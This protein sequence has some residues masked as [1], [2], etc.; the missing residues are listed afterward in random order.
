MEKLSMKVKPRTSMLRGNIAATTLNVLWEN[1]FSVKCSVKSNMNA[2]TLSLWENYVPR[3][4][5][6]LAI[7]YLML[8][9][10]HYEQ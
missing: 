10:K 2:F 5:S 7:F 9:D 1:L 3:V 4:D 8:M 6:D